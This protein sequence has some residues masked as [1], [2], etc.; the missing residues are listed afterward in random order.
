MDLHRTREKPDWEYVDKNDRNLFQRGAAWSHG[1]VT[2]ANALSVLGLGLVNSGIN[3][4]REKKYKQ[5]LIKIGSG[6]LLDIADGW[7]AN[8]TG[9]KSPTGE[10]VDA[11]VD[12]IEMA[13][14]LK[15]LISSRIVPIIP[16][17]IIG[18]QNLSNVIFTGVATY[19]KSEIHSTY[20]GKRAT[21]A[22]W[23]ALGGF[24]ASHYFETQE[25]PVLENIAKGVAYFATGM[26]LNLGSLASV[27]CMGDALGP[28][29]K[30]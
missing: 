25:Q 1:I 27:Y 4:I 9:T 29:T 30:K 12:K 26:D 23:T 6:R 10:A 19:R 3:D 17:A 22:Q 2:P 16:A 21:A 14:A 28:S 11:I 7:V 5:G 13:K 15:S 20:E 18:G 8:K 24:I